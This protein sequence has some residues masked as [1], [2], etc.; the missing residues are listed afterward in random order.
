MAVRLADLLSEI[1]PDTYHRVDHT[2]KRV[3]AALREA[4]RQETGLL[5]NR[6][7]V[8]PADERHS[9]VTVPV[10]LV[11]GLPEPLRDCAFNDDLALVLEISRYR[12][13]LTQAEAGLHGVGPLINQLASHGQGQLLLKGREQAFAF[14]MDLVKELLGLI[15]RN[16]P[17]KRILAVDQDVLG[18]YIYQASPGAGYNAAAEGRVELYW[19][20]IGLVAAMLGASVE[21]LTAVVL[22]H[23]VAHAY[24]HIGADID[25]ER[26]GNHDFARSDHA[27][28]EGLAQYYTDLVSRRLDNQVAETHATYQAL[29]DR[30]PDAY[31]THLGWVKDFKPEEVR[32]AMIGIRRAGP[33]ELRSF[34]QALGEARARLRGTRC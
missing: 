32:L 19:C 29:L 26:W 13:G 5:L 25:G 8:S 6:Q 24:T 21:S 11:V 9:T 12:R 23:E 28:K 3:G 7:E 20:V 4:L 27:L 17:I 16:D 31:R 14:T 22:I 10:S 2:R 18:A 1:D 33:G 34:H 30:Q 15:D